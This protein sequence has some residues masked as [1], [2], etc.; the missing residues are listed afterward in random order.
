MIDAGVKRLLFRSFKGLLC[1]Q[2]KIYNLG[3]QTTLC[4]RLQFVSVEMTKLL[5]KI[6]P[7]FETHYGLSEVD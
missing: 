1:W 2:T 4:F 3:R 5:Q 6:E 7:L